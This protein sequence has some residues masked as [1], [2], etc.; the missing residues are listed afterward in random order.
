FVET[1]VRCGFDSGLACML[2]H[3]CTHC[4]DSSNLPLERLPVVP[5]GNSR[6]DRLDLLDMHRTGGGFRPI[7]V[8]HGNL[9]TLELLGEVTEWIGRIKLDTRIAPAAPVEEDA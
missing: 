4:P 5:F 1:S 8:R 7:W 6:P 3:R 2:L 9:A